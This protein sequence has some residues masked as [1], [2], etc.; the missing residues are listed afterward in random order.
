MPDRRGAQEMKT[1]EVRCLT[2]D[3]KLLDSRDNIQFISDIS[4]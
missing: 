1:F 2:L 4:L 3:F